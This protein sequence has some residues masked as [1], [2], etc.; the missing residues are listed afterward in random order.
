MID[1]N[2]D[3]IVL[4]RTASNG[5]WVVFTKT[6]LPEGCPI[7]WWGV[8][9]DIGGDAHGIL[10][11]LDDRYGPEG[12]TSTDLLQ[13]VV[14]RAKAERH[15]RFPPSDGDQYQHLRLALLAMQARHKTKT[16]PS[17]FQPGPLPS[18]YP[19]TVTVQA[20]RTL[21]LCPDPASQEEGVSPEQVLIV[22]DQL[23][24][25]SIKAL[26]F[27]RSLRAAHLHVQAALDLEVQRVVR[28]RNES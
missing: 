13:V 1:I 7:S 23:L 25:D 27:D 2:E 26:P 21:Q 16:T 19:W 15:R 18:V 9:L 17:S 5:A 20:D 10:V 22:L 14:A 28:C 11:R 12:W 4:A 6:D 24:A 8:A 3:D